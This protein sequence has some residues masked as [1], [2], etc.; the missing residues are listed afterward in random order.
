MEVPEESSMNHV[1]MLEKT[2]TVGK[3]FLSNIALRDFGFYEKTFMSGIAANCC[4]DRFRLLNILPAF[5]TAFDKVHITKADQIF[6][7]FPRFG[8]QT[9]FIPDP[10]QSD[11]REEINQAQ[12]NNQTN[13]L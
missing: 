2:R 1:R 9:L 10:F 13:Y 8:K 7:S 5:E 11:A 6:A 3:L 12:V 4:L